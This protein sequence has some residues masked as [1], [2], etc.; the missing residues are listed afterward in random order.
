MKVLGLL[1]VGNLLH[2]HYYFSQ[3]QQRTLWASNSAAGRLLDAMLSTAVSNS[4]NSSALR[5][6]DPYAMFASRPASPEWLQ[7]RR[8]ARMQRTRPGFVDD[9]SLTPV[10]VSRNEH[11]ILD[12]TAMNKETDSWKQLCKQANMNSGSRVLI[13]HLLSHPTGAALAKLIAKQCGVQQI[14][15]ADPMLPNLRQHRMTLM[16]IQ[17][18]LIR[19]IP[20]LQSIVTE[21]GMGLHEKNRKQPLA[22]MNKIQFS[23]ILLLDPAQSPVLVES[24]G[25]LPSFEIY[26]RQQLR[27][28]W[29]DLSM[30]VQQLPVRVLHVASPLLGDISQAMGLAAVSSWDSRIPFSFATLSLGTLSGPGMLP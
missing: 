24:L 22:W 11:P 29:Q 14:T 3:S 16:D 27:H 10:G 19:K 13:V 12:V 2:A 6:L 23:H 5:Q 7:E 28:V 8:E 20:S 25:G 26:A 9:R 15:G 17:K 21:P 1:A 30:T 18:E 4:S